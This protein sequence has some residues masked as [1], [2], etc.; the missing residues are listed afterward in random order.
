MTCL[1]PCDLHRRVDLKIFLLIALL[2]ESKSPT[3]RVDGEDQL[4]W[5]VAGCISVVEGRR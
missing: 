3:E 1:A 5:S 2:V 4:G